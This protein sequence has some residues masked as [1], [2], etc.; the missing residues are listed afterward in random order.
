MSAPRRWSSSIAYDAA[1]ALRKKDPAAYERES[2]RTMIDH[3]KARG[4]PTL[5]WN[6][7]DPVHFN[8]FQ[9]TATLFDHVF[10]T[11]AGC[12][13]AYLSTPETCNKTV[14]SLPF[15]AQPRIHNPLPSA[16]PW[17]HDVCYA[18]SYYGD[19]YA[20][21]SRRLEDLLEPAISMGLTI[22]DRQH[23]AKDSPY[24][25]PDRLSPFVQGGLDYTDMVQ[26]YKAHAVQVNV[27]SIEDSP[28]NCGRPDVSRS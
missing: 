7:E 13:N 26:A 17:V 10:T 15:F 2:F 24:R 8:R 4:I 28:T 20:D 12:I 1:L 5:F 18:G 9:R 25:F 16:R 19:R 27:N 22:Y 14:S 21:R 11:D 6:K 3:C 23:F